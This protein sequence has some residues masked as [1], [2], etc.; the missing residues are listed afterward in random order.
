[1]KIFVMNFFKVIIALLPIAACCQKKSTLPGG[2][3]VQGVARYS[4]PS[5][6]TTGNNV[7]FYGNSITYG[8]NAS[9][10]TTA[11]WT[12]VF[13]TAV[14]LT[15]TNYGISG[16][17]LVPNPCAANFDTATIA[18]KTASDR[19]LFI[20]YG[21]NDALY[22][23]AITPVAYKSQ[24]LLVIQAAINRG[25]N[26]RR[27]II[28][29]PFY[30]TRYNASMTTPCTQLPTPEAGKELFVTA[31]REAAEAKGAWFIDVYHYM[32]STGGLIDTDSVHPTT[33]GHA[34]IAAYV[35]K[36][37]RL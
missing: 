10:R 4:E 18:T 29:S 11:R 8:L 7:H 27:I 34:A 19:F 16:T 1:M 31:G 21:V 20:S 6:G 15:E 22:T 5:D 26:P 33:A 37:L 2:V 23:S 32:K 28:N 25:W 14:G 24:M 17:T 3:K 13:S 36:M 9:P 30:T 12:T 35:K